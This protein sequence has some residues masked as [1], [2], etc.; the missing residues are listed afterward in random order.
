MQFINKTFLSETEFLLLTNN[1]PKTTSLMDLINWCKKKNAP[2]LD[3]VK[4][5]E[6][7]FDVILGTISLEI[8]ESKKILDNL[9]LIPD[10]T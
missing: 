10:V 8:K 2:I 4:L 3:L 7:T 9:F 1:L 5:D 6:Y